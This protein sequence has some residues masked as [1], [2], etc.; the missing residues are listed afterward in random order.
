MRT[1]TLGA[2]HGCPLD[3]G[4]SAVYCNDPL[5]GPAGPVWLCGISGS[6]TKARRGIRV[7]DWIW[8][9]IAFAL[10]VRSLHPWP[11]PGAGRPGPTAT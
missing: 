11:H 6:I 9:L 10:S 4:D 7:A 1:S 2:E 8:T 5:G 3:P